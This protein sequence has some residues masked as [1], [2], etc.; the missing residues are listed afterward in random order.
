MTDPRPR[1][2]YGEYATPEEQARALGRP[3]PEAHASHD[4]VR[5]QHSSPAA[6]PHHEA[7]AVRPQDGAAPEGVGQ[8]HARRRSRDAVITVTLLAIGLVWVLLSIPSASDFVDTLDH[9]YA[10]QGY[11][12]HYGPVALASTIGLAINISSISLWGI[13]CAVSIVVLR[14]H[15]RAFYIP[16]IGAVL[17]GIVVLSLTLVAM[18][19]DPG[20]I[21]YVNSLQR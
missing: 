2:Q 8:V 12:G 17:A 10:L 11:T 9:T 19:N 18:L 3:A 21:A 20:L 15:R 5:A 4:A 6:L 7:V 16:I 1:P 13:T 14:R